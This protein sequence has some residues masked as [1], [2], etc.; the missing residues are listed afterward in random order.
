MSDQDAATQ[1]F[2]RL[3]ADYERLTHDEGAA[4][5]AEDFDAAQA[6]QERKAPLLETL[7]EMARQLGLAAVM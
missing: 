5:R 1:K 7:G 3:F 6:C 2:W 4:L